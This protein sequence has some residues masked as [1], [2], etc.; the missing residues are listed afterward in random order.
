MLLEAYEGPDNWKMGYSHMGWSV[1]VVIWGAE[2]RF[3][4]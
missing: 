4:I 1:G 3:G 2:Q